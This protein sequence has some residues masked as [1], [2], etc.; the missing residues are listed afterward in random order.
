MITDQL[1]SVLH[2]LEGL[3]NLIIRITRQTPLIFTVFIF[4]IMPSLS[5]TLQGDALIDFRSTQYIHLA[6]IFKSFFPSEGP[7]GILSIVYPGLSNHWTISAGGP[8][9]GKVNAALDP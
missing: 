9:T 5:N 7:S 2:F 1:L 6:T 3:G 4:I 8:L